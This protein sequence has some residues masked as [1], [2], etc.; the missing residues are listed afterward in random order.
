M[1]D[2]VLYQGATDPRD[3]ILHD[4]T[5]AGGN[6]TVNVTGVVSGGLA[7]IATPSGDSNLTAAGVV[8]GGLIG[9]PSVTADANTTPA[10]VVSGGRSGT[11][12]VTGDANATTTGTVS[13][14]RSG[15]C[16]PS[17]DANASCAGAVSGGRL[18]LST[19]T[20]D[21][22]ASITGTVAGGRAGI[23]TVTGD[24][25]AATSGLVSGCRAGLGALSGD[26]NCSGVGVVGGGRVGSIQITGDSNVVPS[27]SA[28]AGVRVGTA[29][30]DTSAL[31][32]VFV[33]GLVSGGRAGTASVTGSANAT[34]TGTV[35][36]GRAGVVIAVG[37]GSAIA[38]GAVS[39]VR[40]GVAA[41]S[42]AG[43][44]SNASVSVTGNKAGVRLGTVRI[45]LGS[46]PI[47]KGSVTVR[48]RT[49]SLFE[50]TSFS[51]VFE[52]I[53]YVF[54]R[55]LIDQFQF[56]SQNMVIGTTRHLEIGAIDVLALANLG[57]DIFGNLIFFE[58]VMAVIA[59][60][61]PGQSQLGM[62]AAAFGLQGEIS[63]DSTGVFVWHNPRGIDVLTGSDIQFQN[64][65]GGNATCDL[66][67]I[68]SAV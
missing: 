16:V 54:G 28:L 35:G 41:V 36:G 1:P 3:V 68:G 61:R 55:S 58:K 46:K 12:T 8:S 11:V 64:Y 56:G 62:R 25:N 60:N 26:A 63:L 18:G 10:G 44:G 27:S 40:A 23:V 45:H 2:I 15:T 34:A 4:P 19:V 14:G 42:L 67:I 43:A 31:T 47:V 66:V 30:A 17:G 24:A 52:R 33:V 49:D 57:H 21:A 13:G 39:G 53:R 65:G 9:S 38:S 6:A 29:T 50:R 5:A 37:D 48:L 22:N 7:G 51:P 20:A 59:H 32:Q